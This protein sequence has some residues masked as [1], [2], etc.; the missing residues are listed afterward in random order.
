MKLLTFAPT[1]ICWWISIVCGHDNRH[2]H[3]HLNF[4]VL[5][6]WGGKGHEPYTTDTEVHVAKQM[7]ETAEDT[8]AK[9]V[10][11]LGDNFYED[12]VD[13]A[14]SKRFH[15]TYTDVFEDLT[16]I[17]WY[18]IAGNHDH[19]GDV[20]AQIDYSDHNHAW[21]FPHLWHSHTWDIPGTDRTLK[22][23]LIDTVKLCGNTHDDD[24]S[25][26]Q[27]AENETLA[28]DQWDWLH[29]E[30]K[31]SDD[32][33]L[34]VGGHYP[35]YSISKHGPTHH[36]VDR[37]KP[38]LEEYDVNAYICGHDHDLQHLNEKHSDVHYAV[39]GAGHKVEEHRRHEDDVPHHSS[40]F[41]WADEDSKG[42]FAHVSAGEDEMRMHFY[43]AGGKLL[44]EFS[45]EPRDIDR[46]KRKGSVQGPWNI[47]WEKFNQ[48]IKIF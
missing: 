1:V 25:Q 12:G 20:S 29:H 3:H 22:L 26:P 7:A 27:G 18:V 11:A 31:H 32:D 13:D 23:V 48:L 16:D 37:L 17:P 47:L 39:V 10:V 40:K 2:H 38:M 43:D 4:L 5:G 15:A 45:M 33:Y 36:L 44:H 35:V 19:H 24:D 28:S 6:D 41:Y 14:D 21:R 30:L 46:K 9:F 42:G 34:I 8:D